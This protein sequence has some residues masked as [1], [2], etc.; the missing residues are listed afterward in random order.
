MMRLEEEA[1]KV[2]AR[3]DF[4]DVERVEAELDKFI[5]KRAR[6]KRE[7]NLIEEEWTRTERRDRQRRREA[8]RLAW[9]D[10]YERMNRLHLGLA[11]EHADKRA[12]LI[13]EAEHTEKDQTEALNGSEEEV[14]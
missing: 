3:E 12:R 9:L 6:E 7:A 2:L 14:A 13:V 8:N 10:F 5:E 4:D 1:A 11:A